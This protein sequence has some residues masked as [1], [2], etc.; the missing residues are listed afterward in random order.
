MPLQVN[1]MTLTLAHRHFNKIILK[2]KETKKEPKRTSDY[3]FCV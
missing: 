3:I 2:K 1:F